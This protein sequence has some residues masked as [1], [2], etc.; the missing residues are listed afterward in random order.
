MP[1]RYR[2][3][4]ATARPSGPGAGP[5]ARGGLPL[6]LLVVA[7]L[8]G[9]TSVRVVDPTTPSLLDRVNSETDGK[10]VRLRL[11]DGREAR[12]TRLVV[13]PD[14]VSYVDVQGRARSLPT[15]ALRQV[16]IRHPERGALQGAGLG[17]L[18]GAAAGGLVGAI[19]YSESGFFT[20]TRLEVV[21]ISAASLGVLGASLGLT[22]GRDRGTRRVYRFR[23]GPPTHGD[24]S[25]P[26]EAT[27]DGGP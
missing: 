17:L 22:V 3:C 21:A 13:G 14:S 8:G 19:V 16:R 4:P 6:L 24:G 27:E 5:F 15:T 25:G 26:H 9:C 11:T 12:G 1:R 18:G 20:F 10:A 7:L 23:H 2:R